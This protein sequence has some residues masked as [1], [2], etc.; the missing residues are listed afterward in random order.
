MT[1]GKII[2]LICLFLICGGASAR[3]LLYRDAEARRLVDLERAWRNIKGDTS[4]LLR[5]RRRNLV[6]G[7]ACFLVISIGMIIYLCMKLLRVIS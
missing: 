1:I 3:M 2:S 7:Y 5:K 4:E 6:V